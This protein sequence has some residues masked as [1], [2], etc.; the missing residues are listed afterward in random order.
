MKYYY[1]YKTPDEFDDILLVSDAFYLTGLYF[2]NRKR[3]NT[4]LDI[5]K[6]TINWL[7]IYFSGKNPN[8][9]P[10][11]KLD[12]SS[13]FRKEVYHILENIQYGEI[14]TYGQIAKTIAKNRGI[15]KMS[16][17]A[18][19]NA[20]GANPICIVDPCHRV[21]GANDNLTGYGGGIK[22]KIALLKLEGHDV[23]KYHLP[24]RSINGK[25]L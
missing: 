17:Q 24:K 3:V 4:D 12:A 23:I 11:Y 7:D 22:N 9:L 25:S 5:F 16:S 8:F 21:V 19:G 18:V 15:S 2:D 10:K 14:V 6:E 13:D 1:N 20:V